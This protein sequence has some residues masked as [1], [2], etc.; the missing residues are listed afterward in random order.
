M[1]IGR[2]KELK[3]ITE[4]LSRHDYQGVFVY[5]R[6]RVGKTELISQGLSEVKMRTLLF[7]FRKVTLQGNLNL[8]IP[9][10]RDFFGD[11]YA[12]FGASQLTVG[13]GA[14]RHV[15]KGSLTSFRQ[16]LQ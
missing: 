9:H 13:N 2:E 12:N 7:E 3:E 15:S 14:C 4:S 16:W 1:F 11:P 6:R 8:F 10:V 5:G